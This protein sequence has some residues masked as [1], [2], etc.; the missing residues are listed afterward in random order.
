MPM[1]TWKALPGLYAERPLTYCAMHWQFLDVVS[2]E[3]TPSQWEEN[4][5]AAVLSIAGWL[6]V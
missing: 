6:V 2:L 1:H 3:R 5:D 4:P